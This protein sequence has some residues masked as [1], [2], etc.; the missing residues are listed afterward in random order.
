LW[1]ERSN[2]VHEVFLDDST[3]G[4]LQTFIA[5]INARAAKSEGK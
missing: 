2:G 4:Q 1:T 5:E 3:M